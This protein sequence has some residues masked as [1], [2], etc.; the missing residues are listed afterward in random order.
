MYIEACRECYEACREC[1]RRA[2]RACG[3]RSVRV[4][5]MSVHVAC[6]K[7]AA[8]R[9]KNSGVLHASLNTWEFPKCYMLSI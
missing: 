5:C 6:V 4:A 3:V 8:E 7:R 1:V 9:A 2:E